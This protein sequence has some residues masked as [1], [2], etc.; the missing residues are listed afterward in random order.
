MGQ[1]YEH[2]RARSSDSV[3]ALAS[4][5]SSSVVMWRFYNLGYT[6][7]RRVRFVVTI[8]VFVDVFAYRNSAR[9]LGQAISGQHNDAR[10]SLKANA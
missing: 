6:E 8:L 10:V 7:F 4:D 5:Q 1:L 9:V 3:I 2:I